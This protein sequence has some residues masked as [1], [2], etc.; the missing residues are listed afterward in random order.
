MLGF[1]Y[2]LLDEEEDKTGRDEGHGKDNA[3]GHHQV[4]G[5]CGPVIEWSTA[6]RKL[7]GE[8][9]VCTRI[10]KKKHGYVKIGVSM[11]LC[12]KCLRLRCR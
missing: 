8:L 10:L 1:V 3:D 9:L 7:T 2:P 11:K 12:T 4:G 6:N 5:G